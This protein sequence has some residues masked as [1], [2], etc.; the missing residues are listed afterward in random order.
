MLLES[1]EV[2]YNL[3]LNYNEFAT[4]LLG[5]FSVSGGV[6]TCLLPWSGQRGRYILKGA[7]V[8]FEFAA[9]T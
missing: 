9:A 8:F 3:S 2:L 7:A 5:N 6:V 4:L 1:V